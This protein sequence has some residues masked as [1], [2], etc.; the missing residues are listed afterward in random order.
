MKDNNNPANYILAMIRDLLKFWYLIAISLMI[1]IGFAAVFL[2]FS[3]K[4]YKIAATV[5]LNID[6]GKSYGGGNPNDIME[7][8]RIIDQHKNFQNELFIFRSTPLIRE[9]VED[10][11]LRTTYYLQEDKIPKELEFSL[12]DIY[13]N[14]PFIVIPDQNH[15]QPVETY[16]YIRIIDQESFLVVS[17]NRDARIIDFTTNE[18]VLEKTNFNFRGTFKFGEEVGNSFCSFRILL[19]S[20][21]RAEL[22]QGK[23]LYFMYNDLNTLTAEYKKNLVV[24]PT[25]LESTMVDLH[26]KSPNSHKGHDFLNILVSKYIQQNLM[27][28]NFLANQTIDHIDRQI[29]SISDSLGVSERQLQSYRS[30]ASVM[31]IDEKAGNIYTQIQTFSA[32]REET[33]RRYNYLR[34]MNEYFTS[35]KDSTGL[36]APS[37]MG[38]NDQL[39]N[40]LIQELTTLNAEKQQFISNDQLLNPRVQTLNV[41]IRNLKN[42]I[43]ENI[44]FSIST[45]RN[46]LNDL[47]SKIKNLE[48]EFSKLPY[49][50]QRL[51][52]IERKF[53]INQGV[54]SSLLEKRI[55]AQIIKSSTLADCELVEPPHYVSI[56][57]PKGIVVLLLAIIIGLL[58]PVSFILGKRIIG[59]RFLDFM[60]LKKYVSVPQIGVIPVNKNAMNNVVL[61]YP[62]SAIAEAFHT[63]RSNLIYYLMGKDHGT[64]LVT[65]S[66]PEEGK[67]FSALNLATSFASTNNKTVLLEFDL[68]K[69]SKVFN[70]LGTRALVGISSYLINR[71]TLDEIIIKTDIPNL[72]IIQTG[73]VPP[74]P[75]ELLS[76]KKNQEL[77]NTLNERY[78]Y[79]IV[80]TPPYSLVSDAFI[81]MKYA[82]IKLYVTR[83]AKVKRSR[84]M[85]N[86]DDISSKLIKDL[87][88]LV[89]ED[90]T[91]KN[92]TYQQY[93]ERDKAKAKAK[94]RSLNKARLKKKPGSPEGQV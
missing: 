84:L 4:K 43:S 26:V 6:E 69:P 31:N 88:L 78:D 21:Y 1:T 10:M 86:M 61:E 39:L 20:Q 44:K 87:Y 16:F 23:D 14:A 15:I 46:E 25:S 30:S 32:T 73:Q 50:Q 91:L 83:L 77:F 2:K 63:I 71:V 34:Q 52:G 55:Q 82:D 81:L 9:V 79:I 66:V 27:E 56:A 65:S 75:V 22:Y 57:S 33:N 74:N 89:N 59:D 67:S 53:E 7:I 70:E 72:D 19:N 80:D 29:S 42:A 38:L 48:R 62:H 68:R 92:S 41:S 17:E 54:Y 8:G 36:L 24:E 40:N 85:A 64:I 90:S 45:S 11:D 47:N 94:K 93:T 12:K 13:K 35:N 58:F 18:T 37:S 5:V 60:D 51:L 28:K 3:A 49:T 76:S